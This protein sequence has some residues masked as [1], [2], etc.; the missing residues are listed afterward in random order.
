MLHKLSTPWDQTGRHDHE[1]FLTSCFHPAHVKLRLPLPA[2]L[3]GHLSS[4]DT[5]W[6]RYWRGMGWGGTGSERGLVLPFHNVQE[7]GERL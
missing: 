2:T 7:N 1:T 3:S 4:E 5:E 6:G